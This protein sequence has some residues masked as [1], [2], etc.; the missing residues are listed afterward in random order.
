MKSQ[1]RFAP[2]GGRF[3]PDSVAF[4]TGICNSSCF[5]KAGAFASRS[6]GICRY[7]RDLDCIFARAENVA[8]SGSV[9]KLYKPPA[10]LRL[11]VSPG[12]PVGCAI[13]P[14]GERLANLFLELDK[15]N[16]LAGYVLDRQRD[17]VL[18]FR[19]G[20]FGEIGIEAF[21]G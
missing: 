9:K 20:H 19:H 15:A 13:R 17:G 7:M 8:R 5:G 4:L 12:F 14:L 1:R 6:A 2:T 3:Q 11:A 18:G 10:F 21:L 16:G